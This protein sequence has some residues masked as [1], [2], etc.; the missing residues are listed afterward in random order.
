M[1]SKLGRKTRIYINRK[2]VPRAPRRQKGAQIRGRGRSL[3]FLPNLDPISSKEDA[4]VGPLY[5]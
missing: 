2:Q 4:H 5:P 1:G 3:D